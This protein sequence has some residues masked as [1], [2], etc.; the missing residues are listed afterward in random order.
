[1]KDKY[2]NMS[3]RNVIGGFLDFDNTYKVFMLSSLS[4]SKLNKGVYGGRYTP[5][6]IIY[7]LNG[8]YIILGCGGEGGYTPVGSFRPQRYSERKAYKCLLI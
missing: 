5:P 3:F 1:M 2:N 6:G 8:G 4:G 7:S